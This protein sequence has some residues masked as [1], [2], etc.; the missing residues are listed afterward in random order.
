MFRFNRLKK[1][2]RGRQIISVFV[3]YGIDYLIDQNKVSL[4]ARI[5][6]RRRYDKSSAAEKFRMA[7]EE[8]GPAFIKFG[9]ILSTRPDFLPPAFIK[10]LEKLQDQSPP[11]DSN[12]AMK[13][14]E[15]ELGKPVDVLFEKFE[16]VPIAAASL[17]QVH[18]AILSDGAIVAIKIQRPDIQETIELDLS[19]L[20]DLAGLV[21]NRLQNGWNYHPK[22]MVEEF[23]KAIRKEMDFSREA[24]NYEKFSNNFKDIDYI[25][26]PKV[27][28]GMTT[29]VVLTME[30]IEGVKINEITQDKYKGI[31]NPRQVAIHG[32]EAILKQILEDGFFHGDPHPANLF[33]QPPANIVMLDVGLVGYLD[34]KTTVEGA[35]LLKAIVDKDAEKTLEI[36]ENLN[37]I[38]AEIDRNLFCQDLVELFDSYLGIPLKNLDLTRIGQEIMEI[39]MR[40]NLVF[41]ANLVLMVKALSM[42]ES[43][44]KSLYPELDILTIA[45]PFVRKISKKKIEPKELIKK[46]ETLLQESLELIEELPQ[47]M[48]MIFQKVQEGKLKFITENQDLK[49]LSRSIGHL[50]AY[51]SLGLIIAALIIGSSLIFIHQQSGLFIFG[52]PILGFI[53]YLIALVLCLIL[54]ISILRT[55]K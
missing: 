40:H 48:N 53:G 30:F 18:K 35:K 50:G 33:V 55:G 29:S 8:L 31:Y 17:S 6:K 26:V 44:G 24:H 9:Q 3:K 45:K 7:L 15:R 38:P 54:V 28:W 52:Y 2:S 39:A 19:I 10:E 49:K 23:K 20:E 41:P 1:I 47:G 25:R 43:T 37:I 14:I 21:E 51:V 34:K 13:I 5:G 16:I 4:L 27:Y 36:F 11:F 42:V 32:A 46:G 12:L 22:L